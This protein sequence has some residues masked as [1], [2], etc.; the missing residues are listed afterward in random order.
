VYAVDA[1]YNDRLP[2]CGSS[3]LKHPLLVNDDDGKDT[4]GCLLTTES[5]KCRSITFAVVC[6]NFQF[7]FNFIYDS[8]H[9]LV[10][11]LWR[12]RWMEAIIGKRCGRCRRV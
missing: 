11:S 8:V 1:T 9:Q 4:W 12:L 3:N 10:T 5:T 7:I 2:D 6:N